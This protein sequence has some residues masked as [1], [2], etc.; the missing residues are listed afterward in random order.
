MN[1]ESVKRIL[2]TDF[3][4]YYPAGGALYDESGTLLEMNRALC[5][6]FGV[7]DQHDFILNNL[8]D[9]DYLSDLQK[10]HLK[11]GSVLVDSLPIGYTIVPGFDKEGNI[12]GYTLLLTDSDL[13][14]QCMIRYDKKMRELKDISDKVVQSVPDTIL[15]INSALVVER[16]ITYASETCITP[17]ALNCR[18]DEL[19]GFIYPDPVKRKVTSVVQESLD[20]SETVNV[21]FSIP[22][23]NAPVVYFKLRLVPIH[24][25]YVVAYIRNVS[26]LVEKENENRNL[27]HQLSESRSMMELALHNSHIATYSFNFELF[28]TCDKEHCNHCFQFYGVNNHLLERNRYICRSLSVLRHPEDRQ[29]FFLLFNEI[30]DKDL[31]EHSVNFRL[32]DDDG[33]YRSYEVIGKAFEKDK[34]G[35]TNLIVGCVIDNQKYVEYEESLIKAKEKAENADLLKSTFLANVTHEIRT[36]LN[37]IVGFSD[38][39]SLEEDPE[40][41]ESYMSLIKANNELLLNLINDVLDISKIESDMLTFNNVDNHLPSVMHGIYKTMQFRVPEHV[42]LV[43]DPCPEIVL[44]MDKNRMMQVL[45]NLLTNAA[46]YTEKGSIRFGCGIQD[47]FVRFYVTDTGSGIPE[48]ELENIFGRFV[49]LKGYKQGIGLGLAICKGLVTKMGGTISATSKVGW[50]STFSF[51]LPLYHE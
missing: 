37:A 50:G 42:T 45:I 32:K 2:L 26:N 31:R 48:S 39:L 20:T 24:H 36:P 51:T 41:R 35:K 49:Q 17:A 27:S 14:D 23:H 8:F 13:S 44:N 25:K 22:G 30:R 21:E 7:K 47:R 18:I 34:G 38:L 33:K 6:K 1:E 19:P 12:I 43:L 5:E 29:D 16:I 46:K 15:L 28:R 10:N 11:N 4:S 3:F 40:L 9:N